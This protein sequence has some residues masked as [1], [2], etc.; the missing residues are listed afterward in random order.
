[1]VGWWVGG[2]PLGRVRG[3]GRFAEGVGF[4]AG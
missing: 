1:M 2:F 3:F 4:K